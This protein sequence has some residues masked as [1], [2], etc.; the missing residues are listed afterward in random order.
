M[1]KYPAIYKSEE[2]T[3][4]LYLDKFNFYCFRR[5]KWQ[6][7]ECPEDHKSDKNNYKNNKNYKT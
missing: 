4:F 5:A 6:K 1:N 7:D 3:P 2:G